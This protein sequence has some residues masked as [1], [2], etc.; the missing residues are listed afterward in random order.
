MAGQGINTVR[1]PISYYHW[2]P[3][4]PDQAARALMSETEYAPYADIYESAHHCILNVVEKAR[5][6]GIGVLIDL[7]GA[8]GGQN[9]EGHCGLSTGNA[10]FFER[11]KNRA[12]TMSVLRTLLDAFA[13]MENVVGI[14]VLNEPRN[15]PK[16]ASF[17]KDSI[18]ELA[19]SR[20]D[21][22]RLPIYLGDCWATQDYARGIA[23]EQNSADARVFIVQDHHLY[24]CFTPGDHGKRAEQHASEIRH[25]HNGPSVSMLRQA[26]STVRGNLVIGE[27][28]AAL[29]HTS[30]R[31]HDQRQQQ[32]LWATAQLDAYNLVCA[33]FFFWTLKKEGPSDTG[34][35]LY[36]AIEQGVLPAGLGQPR[37]AR[38]SAQQL[39]EL[40]QRMCQD[41]F[42]G[43]SSYWSRN[44]NGAP[45]QHEKYRDGYLQAWK[46]AMAFASLDEGRP[47]IS[48]IGFKG[49]W[50]AMRAQSYAQRC[51]NRDN[52]WEFEHGSHKALD[53]FAA[54]LR[55]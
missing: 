1:L 3:G 37:G 44:A 34:W 6:H 36:T 53:D 45:M 14:E 7:H 10:A 33:G 35:C 13:S 31:G 16:L 40:G 50:V 46:D 4:H 18:H 15:N 54:L 28:S 48:E 38:S 52:E 29:H 19:K 20:H 39:A 51:G 5:T 21:H 12:T 9:T 47:G 32:Q 22:A 8:P 41:N 49:Q 25:D 23:E 55:N 26:A 42:N 30:L 43:H 24:R 11:N 2:L 17:Y 27:W